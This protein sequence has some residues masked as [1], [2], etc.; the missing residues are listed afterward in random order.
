[1]AKLFNLARMTTATTGTGTITLGSAVSGFL[2]FALAGVSDGDLVSYG[3]SDGTNSEVGSGIYTSSGTTLTRTVSKSTN[4]DTAINLSGTAQVYITARAEDIFPDETRRNLLLNAIYQS[5]S[6]TGY[7]RFINMFADG[8]KASDGIGVSSS[9]YTVN[10][11]VGN[12]SLSGRLTTGTPTVLS[13]TA[14]NV[15]DNSTGTSIT[16]IGANLSAAAIN[17]RIL[18][19]IDYGSNQ[20]IVKIEAKQFSQSTGGN[21]LSAFFYSTDGTIWTQLGSNIA[22]TETP[23]DFNVTG[24]VT[25]R[26]VALIL[27]QVDYTS[28]NVTLS[29]ING[30]IGTMTLVTTAQTADSTVN[31][32]RVLV[33]FDNSV[34]PTLNTDLTIEV[35]CNGGSNW[36]SAS[37]SLVS[38]NGQAGRVIAET[39]DQKT[40]AGTSFSARIKTLNN[41]VIPIYGVS[42]TVH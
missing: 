38:S 27:G 13:G 14:A 31:S 40:T 15:N 24:S 34:S 7:R 26:Y 42:L 28:L 12:V 18:A 16:W 32:G 5:K 29:D 11:S 3:I 20:T 21:S 37:L 9:C 6:F 17:S 25:A 4:S 2:T 22:V 8:Y 39:V 33:D 41:K 35:T 36:D 10:T 19:K 1:M 30:Y 23:T